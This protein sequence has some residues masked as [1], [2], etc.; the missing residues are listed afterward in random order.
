MNS[1]HTDDLKITF[2][3]HS[4]GIPISYVGLTISFI[5]H[6]VSCCF[7]R[8]TLHRI[9]MTIWHSHSTCISH[10][11]DLITPPYGITT[12]G[13]FYGRLN[14]SSVW[15]N[16]S[17]PMPC[18]GVNSAPTSA[19]YM[20]QWIGSTLIQIIACCLFGTKPLSK[21]ML[22]YCQLDSSEQ[23]SVNF[24]SRYKLFIHEN[25]TE[26]SVCEMAANLFRC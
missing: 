15:H 20:R 26:N 12:V 11:D 6:K 16:N 23:T 24:Q 22:G 2:V 7:I 1:S 13:I 21:P 10:T 4:N 19:A 3:W 14:K 8:R 5:W 25:E 18:G 17:I 9:R